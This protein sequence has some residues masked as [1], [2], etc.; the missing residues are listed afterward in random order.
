MYSLAEMVL[1]SRQMF[2]CS[3][4]H[5]S[6]CSSNRSRECV[7]NEA[8][9][10]GRKQIHCYYLL[11]LSIS[12]AL[13]YRWEP[14]KKYIHEDRGKK[15]AKGEIVKWGP[16][17]GE[18]EV[19]MT[20]AIVKTAFALLYCT[21]WRPQQHP[22]SQINKRFNALLAT[23]FPGVQPPTIDLDPALDLWEAA[24]W[25]SAEVSRCQDT[26]RSI[27]H[28]GQRSSGSHCPSVRGSTQAIC[29]LRWNDTICHNEG[30]DQ[31]GVVGDYI[32]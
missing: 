12:V 9:N 23:Q 30:F 11:A 28:R 25:V 1:V 7:K 32:A 16:E 2:S 4:W 10:K 5:C 19:A 13:Y 21:V 17:D 14:T 3:L 20:K 24:I 22:N 6:D 8:S 26:Q 27:T 31:R 18:V 15:S 29:I